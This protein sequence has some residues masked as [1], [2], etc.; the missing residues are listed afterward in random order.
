[1]S[2]GGGEEEI[3]LF[4][5]MILCVMRRRGGTNCICQNVDIIA[6]F[7]ENQDGNFCNNVR[8]DGGLVELSE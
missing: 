1:M 7:C 8:K 3:R 6:E 4:V 5:R 2:V